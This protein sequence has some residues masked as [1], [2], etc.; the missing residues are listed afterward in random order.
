MPLR[1]VDFGAGQGI[2][3][4][5]SKAEPLEKLRSPVGSGWTW[6]RWYIVWFLIPSG[7]F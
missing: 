1:F 3:R 2:A 7:P 4:P 5:T 6:Y